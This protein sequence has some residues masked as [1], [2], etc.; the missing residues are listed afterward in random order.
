[1]VYLVLSGFDCDVV[2]FLLK[3]IK[4]L[5][6]SHPAYQQAQYPSYH[7]Y[8]PQTTNIIAPSKPDDDEAKSGGPKQRPLPQNG[9]RIGR[10]KLRQTL[11]L[12]LQEEN[13]QEE[14]ARQVRLMQLIFIYFIFIQFF[15]I[16]DKNSL[17]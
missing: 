3:P 2:I 13:L 9:S 5:F 7:H 16:F 14:E 6:F 11:L 8:K 17:N 15:L 10:K 4:L 12:P 1:M